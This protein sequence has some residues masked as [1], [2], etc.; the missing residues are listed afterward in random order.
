LRG[1]ERKQEKAI[2]EH[3]K[4]HTVRQ[5]QKDDANLE[6]MRSGNYAFVRSLAVLR[7][8]RS[9]VGYDNIIFDSYLHDF[10]EVLYD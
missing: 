7:L 2:L 8:A 10:I 5:R 9:E 6:S 4:A 1:T 3:E